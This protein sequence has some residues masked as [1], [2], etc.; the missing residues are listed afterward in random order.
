MS[1]DVLYLN[2][3]LSAAPSLMVDRPVKIA[4]LQPPLVQENLCLNSGSGVGAPLTAFHC[5]IPD[6]WHTQCPL[7]MHSNPKGLASIFSNGFT[8]VC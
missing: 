2:W 7:A 1:K 8:A 4:Q 3:P 6:L 5:I